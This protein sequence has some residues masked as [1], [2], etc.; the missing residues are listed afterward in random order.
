MTEQNEST[1][2]T[3]LVTIETGLPRQSTQLKKVARQAEE[4][5]K[6]KAG[7][8]SSSSYYWKWD[9]ES[10]H[11]NGLESLMQFQNHYRATITHYARF[12][13]AA[14]ALMLPAG[15][16]EQ[17]IKAKLELD[18]QWPE[19]RKEWLGKQYPL[20]AAAAPERMGGFHNPADFPTWD[21]CDDRIICEC[22][23]IPLAPAEQVKRIALLSPDI[24]ATI[25]QSTN[26]SYE[27]GKKDAN[28]KLF[29]EVMAPIQNMVDVLSK[30]KSKIYDT[31]VGNIISIVDLVPAYN[32]VFKDEHLANLASAAK[33]AFSEI[34][35]DDLRKSDEARKDALEK[36]KNIMTAFKP[37][38][39]KLAV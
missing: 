12:P 34:K 1:P 29:A 2:Q 22:K 18:K 31:L 28:E 7:T 8:V 36:A 32:N 25:E 39:R 14:G 10:G 37:Y 15:L 35:T 26:S 11:H 3:L 19:V 23:I 21:D 24:A 33:A 30:D 13:F 38:Q 27:K 20:L 6:A 16:A 17:C 5:A 9:D 4:K